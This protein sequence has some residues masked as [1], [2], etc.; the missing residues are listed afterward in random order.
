MAGQQLRCD[1]RRHGHDGSASERADERAERRLAPA[2]KIPLQVAH[3]IPGRD[4]AADRKGETET[5]EQSRAIQVHDGSNADSADNHVDD[6]SAQRISGVVT[7]IAGVRRHQEQGLADDG[8][9]QAQQRRRDQPPAG[10]AESADP[11]RARQ[12]RGEDSV[13]PLPPA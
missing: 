3:Q 5:G 8:W 7:R 1:P 4:D 10:R 12:R 9:R 6:H 13:S 2:R 11:D